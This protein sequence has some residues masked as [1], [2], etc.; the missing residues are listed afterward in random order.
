MQPAV[1]YIPYSACSKEQTGD[2]ITFAPFEEGNVPLES[3]NNAKSSNKY[4]DDSTLP[5]SSSE[6]EINVVS[7]GDA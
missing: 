3:R 1:S 2:I 7:S 6:A 4:D 5:P